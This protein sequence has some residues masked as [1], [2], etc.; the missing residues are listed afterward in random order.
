[1]IFYCANS[2]I[3]DAKLRCYLLQQGICKSKSV[4]YIER[5]FIYKNTM[6][7]TV[8]MKHEA[9]MLSARAKGKWLLLCGCLMAHM[10]SEIRQILEAVFFFL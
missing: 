10:K 8:G 9:T 5:N 6:L 3:N 4:L 7:S 2:Q 1:M